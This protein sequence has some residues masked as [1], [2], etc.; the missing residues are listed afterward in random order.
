MFG[1]PCSRR[2]CS[3]GQQ[4]PEGGLHV[5]PAEQVQ[6]PAPPKPAAVFEHPVSF[7]QNETAH[8]DAEAT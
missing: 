1:F 2:E 6:T 4:L 5:A 8:T 3:P 7:S